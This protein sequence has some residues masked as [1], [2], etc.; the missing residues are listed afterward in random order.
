LVIEM[1]DTV[2][3]D[4]GACMASVRVLLIVGLVGALMVWVVAPAVPVSGGGPPSAQSAAAN[5]SRPH[6]SDKAHPRLNLELRRL[7][8]SLASMPSPTAAHRDPFRFAGDAHGRPD[9]ES[10]RT[11][12]A[13]TAGATDAETPSD[14][15]SMQLLGIAEDGDP[16]AVERTA[17]IAT[18]RHVYMVK[19]GEQIAFRFQVARIG[20]DAVELR[21]LAQD[22]TFTLALR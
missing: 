8:T 20:A 1:A 19:E 15:P 14:R 4:R 6:P 17:V 9:T 22:A 2:H 3:Y 11:P 21:D 12:A 18:P 16:P 5:G 7:H 13:A 10:V